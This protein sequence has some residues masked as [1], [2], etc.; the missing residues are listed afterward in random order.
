MANSALPGLSNS[1]IALNIIHP[2][3]RIINIDLIGLVALFD[4]QER[5]PPSITKDDSL[6]FS[7]RKFHQRLLVTK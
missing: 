5:L 4:L 6:L 1:E 3:L 7:T 2:G